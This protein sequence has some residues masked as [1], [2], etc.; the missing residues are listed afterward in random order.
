MRFPYAATLFL[1]LVFAGT[2]WYQTSAAICPAPLSYRLGDLDES[3]GL[4]REE[5]K[6]QIQKAEAIWESE[7]T[8]ELFVYDEAS[9]FTI[10]FVYDERQALANSEETER[11]VLDKQ[12][13]QNEEIL[14]TVESMQREYQTLTKKYEQQV[15]SY[16]SRLTEYNREVSKYNDRGGAPADVFAELEKERK[17]LTKES[18]AL[19][20]TIATLK[21]LADEIN[22][23]SE[24]GNR[25][26]DEYN[27]E[28]NAYNS[29]Y[30][31]EREF[32]Q[33]DYQ[34]VKIHVYKFSSETELIT[35]LAHEFGHALGIDHVEGSSSLM[36][37]L[38]DDTSSSPKLSEEDK[39]AYLESCGE[40][41]SLEQK[42]RRT[43]RSILAM[44]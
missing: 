23:L 17:A 38:L 39:V 1:S 35:V 4:T 31:F 41:E 11:E 3:F 5:A 14:A 37:Y 18:D 34:G 19:N 32:T 27:R 21:S 9:D 25:L 7:T 24:K 6:E 10:D 30:G 43:I 12:K 8:R 42:I 26:V 16:E 44:F 2:Y 33:G 36:Y 15:N 29:Q 20:K 22:K 40:T 13:I 28:V